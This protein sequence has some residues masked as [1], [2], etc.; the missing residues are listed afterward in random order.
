[1]WWCPASSLPSSG[2]ATSFILYLGSRP[3]EKDKSRKQGKRFLQR[4]SIKIMVNKNRQR[5]RLLC[6]GH[7]AYGDPAAENRHVQIYRIHP[8]EEKAVQ[9]RRTCVCPLSLRYGLEQRCLLCV[10]ESCALRRLISRSESFRQYP[11]CRCNP[12]AKRH[13]RGC[14]PPFLPFLLFRRCRRQNKC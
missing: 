2:S 1:M 8:T 3:Y 11:W 4:V 12:S 6:R 5:G 14:A 10:R 9:A 7:P 13:S